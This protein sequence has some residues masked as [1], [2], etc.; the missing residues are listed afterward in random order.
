MTKKIVVLLFVGALFSLAH[1]FGSL[2]ARMPGSNNAFVPLWLKTL[3]ATVTISDQIAVTFVDQVFA[4]T[5]SSKK[6]GIYNFTLPDGAVIMELA[7]WING[8]RQVAKPME[9]TQAT[10]QYDNSVRLSVDPALLTD[11]GNNEYQIHVYPLNAAGDSLAHRRIDFTYV[12]PLKSWLDTA[13]YF[14]PLKTTGLS[15]QAPV[16]TSVSVTITSQDTIVNVLVP[17]FSNTEIALTKNNEKSFNLL[18]NKENSYTDKDFTLTII[19]AHTPEFKL[20]TAS[21]VPGLDTTLSFD[22]TETAQYFTMW[23]ASPASTGTAVKPREAVFVVDAS[24]SMAG[25]KFT[26][27]M[28]SLRHAIGLLSA[29][30]RFN[31]I[32]FN[33]TYRAFMPSL[34]PATV[35]NLAQALAFL[36][37][38]QTAGITNPCDAIK[39]AFASPWASSANHGVFLLSDGYVNWP[40]RTSSSMM[41]DTLTAAN[42]AQAQLYSIAMGN[43]ADQAFLSILSQRNG[44][45]LVTLAAPDTVQGGDLSNILEQM[46]YPLLYDIK[47]NIIGLDSYGIYPSILPNLLD[48]GQLSVYGR[49]A[50]AGSYPVVLS[51]NRDGIVVRETLTTTL[52]VPKINYRSIPQLWASAKVDDLLNQIKL[53]GELPALKQAVITLGLKYGIVTP[54]T[55]LIVIES[56]PGGA[57]V[58]PIL[59]KTDG[60]VV[61]KMELIPLSTK[62]SNF[63]LI[64][65][66]YAV[67]TSPGLKM[68]SLK[69]YNLRG[70]LIRTIAEYMTSGGWFSAN[71]DGRD[72]RGKSIGTGYYIVV[73]QVANQRIA[74]PLRI[75]R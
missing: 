16:R 74:A 20:K 55:S 61:G 29:T 28:A 39:Q 42:T 27:I 58:H 41:I 72:R 64:R 22:S 62:F 17:G 63:S 35:A 56:Q 48:G 14:F 32:V 47:L 2:K 65:I 23:L 13:A 37:T 11:L 19:G 49:Y 31:I 67:P 43:D 51:A 15:S 46:L 75:V 25:N 8:K 9:K 5:D 52:P 24:F 45:F 50:K 59:D 69:V 70:E 34:V 6:E 44:G 38:V 26:Q 73:L 57:G 40:L 30:D 21:Y 18:Y 12:V 60:N 71:W 53:S 54:Y 3:D 1:G 66:K 10:S 68:V 36:Q 33:T 7:L 4:N